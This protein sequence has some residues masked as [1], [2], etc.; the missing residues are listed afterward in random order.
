MI[1][2]L[3][4]VHNEAGLASAEPGSR[5]QGAERVGGGRAEA[6]HPQ[7]WGAQEEP[8]SH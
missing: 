1:S 8:A 6:P 7:G 5:G 2:L 4:E 3:Y